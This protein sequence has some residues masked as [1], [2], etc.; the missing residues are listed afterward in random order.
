MT[1]GDFC[2]SHPTIPNEN[3]EKQKWVWDLIYHLTS[4][5]QKCIGGI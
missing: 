2:Y 4:A 1:P 3:N 5:F